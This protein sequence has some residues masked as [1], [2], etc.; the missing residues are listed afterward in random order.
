[1]IN[2]GFPKPCGQWRLKDFSQGGAKS[3]NFSYKGARGARAI[4]FCPPLSIFCPPL[5]ICSG[6]GKI[7]S[8]G[9]KKKQVFF[10]HIKG[11]KNAFSYE[12]DPP[13]EQNF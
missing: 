9:G 5:S 3:I 6:G 2:F 7:Y 10:S 1:M 11:A 12:F 4:F 8:G 13:P